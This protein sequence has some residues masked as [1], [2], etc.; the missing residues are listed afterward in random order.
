MKFVSYRNMIKSF[1]RQS[2]GAPRGLSQS[3]RMQAHCGF[4]PPDAY[5]Y[6]KTPSTK[7]I[8]NAFISMAMSAGTCR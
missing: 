3:V 5:R 7:F 8:V 2:G 6:D 1:F 4:A